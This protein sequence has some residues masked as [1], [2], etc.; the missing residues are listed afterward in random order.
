MIEKI[1]TNTRCI[2][3]CCIYL[4]EC[5][6]CSSTIATNKE[7]DTIMALKIKHIFLHSLFNLGELIPVVRMYAHRSA[8]VKR[9][10]CRLTQVNK[11]QVKSCGSRVATMG[12]LAAGSQP[13]DLL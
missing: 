10:S 1:R 7:H 5:Y 4:Y 3:K 6:V 9:R 2:T 8:G 12:I 11:T 13:T